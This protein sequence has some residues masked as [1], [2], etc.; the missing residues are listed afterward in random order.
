MK[1]DLPCGMKKLFHVKLISP[2][3]N[4]LNR[5]NKLISFDLS[6]FSCI[7]AMRYLSSVVP[8]GG[9]KED[10]LCALRDFVNPLRLTF[11][12][13]MKLFNLVNIVPSMTRS[14]LDDMD[15]I[16]KNCHLKR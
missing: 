10:A 9:T 7:P 2:G 4:K 14:C 3:F 15:E 5:H 16:N 11:L 8:Q 13:E 12:E 6:F 1:C